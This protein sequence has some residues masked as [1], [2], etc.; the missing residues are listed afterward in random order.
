MLGETT[1]PEYIN[2]AFFLFFTECLTYSI[3]NNQ[4]MNQTYSIIQMFT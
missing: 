4:N 2:Y 1:E 3:A